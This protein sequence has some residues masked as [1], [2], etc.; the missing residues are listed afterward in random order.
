V[1]V[2]DA[3]NLLLLKGLKSFS[4]ILDQGITPP[5][6]SV[7]NASALNHLPPLPPQESASLPST[8][9]PLSELPSTDFPVSVVELFSNLLFLPQW[10]VDLVGATR[11][12]LGAAARYVEGMLNSGLRR[13]I[14][15][16]LPEKEF[17]KKATQGKCSTENARSKG[18]LVAL[19]KLLPLLAEPLVIK[20]LSN[21][22]AEPVKKADG[23]ILASPPC[24]LGINAL[25]Q[26]LVVE[27]IRGT[28]NLLNGEPIAPDIFIE[29]AETQGEPPVLWWYHEDNISLPSTRRRQRAM[30]STTFWEQAPRVYWE[31]VQCF[32]VTPNQ[33]VVAEEIGLSKRTFVT[34]LDIYN[35][36]WPP[37]RL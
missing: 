7:V 11:C 24:A 27:T 21:S 12:D 37:P 14:N 15:Y 31:Y 4:E 35:M 20:L 34:Y 9:L 17:R 8:V 13:R 25:R 23:S 18:M 29:G 28:R 30:D 1:S 32:S 19:I 2:W 16:L 22:V 3:P 5:I 26:W 6:E 36:P 10:S 33:E